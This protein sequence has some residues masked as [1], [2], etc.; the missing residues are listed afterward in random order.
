MHSITQHPAR[1]N[2]DRSAFTLVEM[3]VSVTLVLLMMTLFASI[4]QMATG[5]MS[6]Q[7]A[8]AEHDQR[9][10]TLTNI[11]RSDFQKRTIRTAFPFHPDEDSATSQVVPFPSRA[12]YF[13]I[14]TNA[15]DSPDD[16]IQFTVD[17]NITK[18]NPDT[19]AFYANA[20]QLEDRRTNGSPSA[21][22]LAISPN[23]PE[24]DDGSIAANFVGSS[25]A[26][27]ITY[28]VRRGNLYRRV[29]L[30][31][32]PIRFAGQNLAPQP[33]ST[34]GYD[35]FFGQPDTTA[36][37][38]Y[39][40]L[41]QPTFGPLS[42]DFYRLFDYSAYSSELRGPGLRQAVFLGTATLS[43]EVAGGAAEFLAMPHRRFGFNPVTG[44][45]REFTVTPDAGFGVPKFI[46]RPLHAETSTLNF[47]WPQGTA[48]NEPIS[49]IDDTVPDLAQVLEVDLDFDGSSDATTNGN[50]LDIVNCPLALNPGNGLISSF[51][52]SNT[53]AEGR[54]GS[55]AMDDLLLS[56]V[57]ELKVELWDERLQKFV[58]PGN[59]ET[60]PDPLTGAPIPGDYSMARCLNHE[61]RVFP[62]TATV[63]QSY[64]GRMFDTWHPNVDLDFD[65]V[66]GI[67]PVEQNPPYLP[68]R[69]YPPLPDAA[70]GIIAPPVPT[71]GA[72][73]PP[74]PSADA[75]NKGYWTPNTPYVIGDVVFRP[76]SDGNGNGVFEYTDWTNWNAGFQIAHRCVVAGT[77][78]GSVP[79]F[80]SAKGRKTSENPIGAGVVWES[81]DNTRPLRSV[82]LQIRFYDKVSDTMRQVSLVIPVTD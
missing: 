42:N 65:G 4:F 48:R 1:Q 21:T 50:P 79:S 59:F 71:T 40:G 6:A 14:S 3:L 74:D 8:I 10:R 78:V 37:G 16:L 36:V 81:F 54:G 20:V 72:L 66:G 30:I 2:A 62:G 22:G 63:A 73:T 76:Y 18:E 27:E 82:R 77:S 28:F 47:N 69:F 64:I 32:E 31:R 29:M 7:R 43:N 41:F 12:G 23:Q 44:L 11:I 80:Q 60:R 13:Y 70:A 26:A 35:Y 56:N 39:D 51:D 58:P 53:L 55:R 52:G 57:H 49:S 67:T 45:S 17:A 19:T 61:Y 9:A 15:P 5:S 25:P 38:T 24:M 34:S 75:W 46:G 33:T 68:Y